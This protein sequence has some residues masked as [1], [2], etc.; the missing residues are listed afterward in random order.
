MNLPRRRLPKR[1]SQA[2]QR[3]RDRAQQRDDDWFDFK[4]RVLA[5]TPRGHGDCV[6]TPWCPTTAPHRGDTAHHKHQRSLGG[7]NATTNGLWVCRQA[8][9]GIHNNIARATDL[10]LLASSSDPWP[11]ES[12]P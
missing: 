11:G 4:D 3:R 10:G 8:H 12:T 1:S 2:Q 6:G 9:D 5:A 7:T